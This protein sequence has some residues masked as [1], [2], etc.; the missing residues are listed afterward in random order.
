[1]GP[2]ND[3]LAFDPDSTAAGLSPSNQRTAMSTDL[4]LSLPASMN[5]QPVDLAS[6]RESMFR[7]P[8]GKQSFGG[9]AGFSSGEV[10][11]QRS[12]S[13]R[14]IAEGF[15]QPLRKDSLRPKVGID[16]LPETASQKLQDGA[17]SDPAKPSSLFHARPGASSIAQP[18]GP[19]TNTH[20]DPL[21]VP[22]QPP[23]ALAPSSE[24]PLSDIFL[25]A[26]RK[27]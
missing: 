7:G 22:L 23:S 10:S 4:A 20:W 6:V 19:H 14:R 13:R 1:M 8:H 15:F 11:P 27:A 18:V 2:M 25:Q 21:T 24:L 3:S 9:F 16:A 12:G 26:N 17:G 5:F